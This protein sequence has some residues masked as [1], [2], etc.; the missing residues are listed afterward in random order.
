MTVNIIC[1][2]YTHT[3][4]VSVSLCVHTTQWTTLGTHKVRRIHTH[5]TVKNLVNN[6]FFFIIYQA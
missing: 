5:Y 1:D 2:A 3:D 6:Y 4:I